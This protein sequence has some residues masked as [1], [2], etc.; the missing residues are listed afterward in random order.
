[1]YIFKISV[2]LYY[3]GCLVFI[4]NADVYPS[5]LAVIPVENECKSF[6]EILMVWIW[7]KL[8]T[9]HFNMKI[10]VL[11]TNAIIFQIGCGFFTKTIF[12]SHIQRKQIFGCFP[13]NRCYKKKILRSFERTFWNLWPDKITLLF[14]DFVLT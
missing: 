6:S 14:D 5:Y 12:W 13:N 2:L 4:W 3:W 7:E 8:S 9:F 1:M 10:G 11:M